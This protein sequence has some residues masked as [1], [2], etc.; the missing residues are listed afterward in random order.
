VKQRI[1]KIT[2]HVLTEPD[3]FT[4]D[5]VK[6]KAVLDTVHLVKTTTAHDL[7]LAFGAQVDVLADLEVM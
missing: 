1:L 3:A 6:A 7:T 5:V 4:S 2:L